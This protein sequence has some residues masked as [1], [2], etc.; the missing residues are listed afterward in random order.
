MGTVIVLRSSL[1]FDPFQ[2]FRLTLTVLGLE[3][4]KASGYWIDKGRHLLRGQ[5]NR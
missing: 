5:V 2:T 3:G 1:Y 4:T